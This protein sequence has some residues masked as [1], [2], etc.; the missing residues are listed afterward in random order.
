MNKSTNMTENKNWWSRLKSGL[1]KTSDKLEDGLKNVFV[2]KRLDQE[3][4][5][6]LEDLLILSDMGVETASRLTQ[7]LAKEKMDKDVTIEEIKEFLAE[8]IS[9]I[10]SPF[11]T[12]LTLT[13][14]SPQVILVVG[15]NGSGKTTTI[16]KLAK[17]W[18]D[19]GKKVRLVA[20]DTFRAAAVEQLQVWAQRTKV[21]ITIGQ[22]NADS[23]GLAYDALNLAKNE[24]CDILIIDTAGRLHNKAGLMD[25]LKKISRVIQ[26]IDPTCPH[27]VLLVLDATTGQNAHAQVQ[28]FKEMIGVT[29]LIVTK[30]DGTAKGGVVVSLCNKF[31]LPIHAIG[32]GESVD[33]L[34]PFTAQD[35]ARTLVG[36]DS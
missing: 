26:K 16:G 8:R 6:E 12:P 15:V 5:D 28:T 2:R 23:A 18:S 7:D 29:G 19:E 17:Q 35:F 34:R 27:N 13:N 11:A 1:K 24:G 3:T 33:D 32:V 20:G 21:P 30:L 36:I 9:S 10:L 25:E 31:Q 4:L 14:T 22:E